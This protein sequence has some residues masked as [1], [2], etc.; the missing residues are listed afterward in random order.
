MHP[1]TWPAQA[2]LAALH[3]K[4]KRTP[5]E[6]ARFGELQRLSGRSW[7]TFIWT[8]R[9]AGATQGFGEAVGEFFGSTSPPANL[10]YRFWIHM[11]V[12]WLFATKKKGMSWADAIRAYNGSGA[13]AQHYREA[14]LKRAVDAAARRPG[15]PL[16]PAGI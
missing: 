8:Y 5:E 2:K 13:A 4:A 10:D 6:R 1:R 15:S 14:V 11:A 12:L 7:E 9:A 16:I 3:K